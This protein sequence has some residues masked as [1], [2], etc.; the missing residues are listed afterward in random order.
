MSILL[1][2][3]F[4]VLV[5]TVQYIIQVVRKRQAGQTSIPA[6]TVQQPSID[7]KVDDYL[8][9]EG[10]FFH[11]SHTW[12]QVQESGFVKIGIDDFT[13]KVFREI[14]TVQLKAAGEKVNQ[15]DPILTV[16]HGEN[17]IELKAPVSGE[18]IS[19]NAKLSTNPAIIKNSPYEDGWIY[20][21][22]PS[23]LAKEI[24]SL[25]IAENARDWLKNEINRLREFLMF[26]FSEGRVLQNTMADG[27]IPAEGIMEYLDK[28][29]WKKLNDAFFV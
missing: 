24:K 21:L 14:E 12:A 22:K 26:Q 8:L 3:A 17:T 15:G 2:I 19:T 5:I 7:M 20:Q 13:Q 6:N 4:V 16:Q 29:S 9:P 27:G 1:L 18:I 25:R 11:R 23:Q 28:G 10:L